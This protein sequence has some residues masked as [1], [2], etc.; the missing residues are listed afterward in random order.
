MAALAGSIV[1]LLYGEKWLSAI[2]LVPLAVVVASL[3]ALTQALSVLLLSTGRQRFCFYADCISS[4]G[5]VMSLLILL[6][7]GTETY[8][9]GMLASQSCSILA[10]LVWL[11]RSEA[12]E[13]RRTLRVTLTPLVAAGALLALSAPLYLRANATPWPFAWIAAFALVFTVCYLAILRLAASRLMAEFV[14]Y[15]PGTKTLRR[16]LFL[17]S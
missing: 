6:P 17:P 10:M 15:C 8:L 5:V 9:L 16:L 14:A 1:R 11:H 7:R 3:T 13:F 2:P 12:L 4:A